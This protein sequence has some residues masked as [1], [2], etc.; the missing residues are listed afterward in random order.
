[1]KKTLLICLLFVTGCAT[2]P[3]LVKTPFPTPPAELMEKPAELKT[4]RKTSTISESHLTD[5]SPSNIDLNTVIRITAENMGT[6]NKYRDQIFGLQEWITR[7]Q[8][9]TNERK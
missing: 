3:V 8:A 2:E 4:I 7:Q 1:M 5:T 6:C 9:I